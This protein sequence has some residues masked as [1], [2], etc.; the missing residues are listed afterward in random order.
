[1]ELTNVL[2]YKDIATKKEGCKY[3]N[4]DFVFVSNLLDL[5]NLRLLI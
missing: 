3:F 5:G 1:V 2:T 4:K